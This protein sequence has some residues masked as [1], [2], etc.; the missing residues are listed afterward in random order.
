MHNNIIERL[1][2][3]AVYDESIID[4]IEFASRNGFSGIQVAVESPHLSPENL[5]P[6]DKAEIRQR[7]SELGI[8]ITLHGPDNVA[9]LLQTN[10]QIRKG[11]LSYYQDLFTF[12][13]D[14]GAVLTTIHIGQPIIYATDTEPEVRIPDVDIEDY[15]EALDKN[16]RSIVDLA[17]NNVPVCVENYLLEDF[18]LSV[19]DKYIPKGEISLCWDIAKT[20]N[21]DGSINKPLLHYMQDNRLTVR[22]VHLHDINK[23]G[24]S[25]RTIGTGNINFG[26]YLELLSDV[27]V[28]DYCIEVRPREK[29]V[30]S[31]NYLKG[32][33]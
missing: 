30:E 13:S 19:L 6:V 4:A 18:V 8:R 10:T 29:A 25:H 32:M 12:A 26:N 2:Y 28:W 16:L 23:Q 31:L 27:D 24:R 21:K 17:R 9:S 33:L 22:Q 5:S 7:R 14:I 1:S 15:E 3:H 11:I 20:Y